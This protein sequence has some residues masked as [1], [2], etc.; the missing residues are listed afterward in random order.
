MGSVLSPKLGFELPF[1]AAAYLS[2]ILSPDLATAFE[3]GRE[4]HLIYPS[5]KDPLS[6]D[7][8]DQ[9]KRKD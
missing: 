3:S 5:K 6:S 8:N 9:I 2:Y 1:V 4:F 7:E